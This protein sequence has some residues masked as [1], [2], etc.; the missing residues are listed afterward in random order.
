MRLSLYGDNVIWNTFV[1]S[2]RSSGGYQAPTGYDK[3]KA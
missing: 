2:G 3:K 1:E